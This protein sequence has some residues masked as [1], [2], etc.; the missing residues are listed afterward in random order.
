MSN[1]TENYDKYLEHVLQ[2]HPSWIEFTINAKGEEKLSFKNLPNEEKLTKFPEEFQLEVK[3]LYRDQLELDSINS[4]IEK[5]VYNLH[6]LTG[7]YW[8]LLLPD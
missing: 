5:T 3:N 8:Y 6:L 4:R 1:L 2:L 7:K